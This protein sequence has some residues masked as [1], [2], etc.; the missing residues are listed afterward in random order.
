MNVLALP[1]SSMVSWSG[2]SDP[3]YPDFV[4]W[5]QNVMGVPP[6][7]MPDDTTLQWAYDMGLNL[8]LP[9]LQTIPC[10]PTSPS[11]YAAAVYNLGGDRLVHMAQD[12]PPSTYWSD[13]RKKFGVGTFSPGFTTGAA[14]QGTSQSMTILNQV[15]DFTMFD[16]ALSKTPWG[17]AYIEIVS[18]WGTYWNIS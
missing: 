4:L 11:I 3:N 8:A 13:L 7:N 14:D 15:Q 12:T 9:E 16:L 10:Q 1:P 6:A 2:D 17:L 18:S 5:V